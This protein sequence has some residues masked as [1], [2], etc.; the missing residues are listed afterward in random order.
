MMTMKFSPYKYIVIYE[1]MLLKV[2]NFCKCQCF[3]ND[4]H[5]PDGDETKKQKLWNDISCLL[6]EARRKFREVRSLS[7]PK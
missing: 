4:G 3:R 5:W 2:Y 6:D 7:K 1:L